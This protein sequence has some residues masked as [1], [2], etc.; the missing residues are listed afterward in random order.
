[1]KDSKG[2]SRRKDDFFDLKVEAEKSEKL[3]QFYLRKIELT[4]GK[5]NENDQMKEKLKG[6]GLQAGF[7]LSSKLLKSLGADIAAIE[8]VLKPKKK[9]KTTPKDDLNAFSTA[10]KVGLGMGMETGAQVEGEKTESKASRS[11][12]AKILQK[13]AKEA[14]DKSQKEKAEKVSMIR[15]KGKKYEKRLKLLKEK[16]KNKILE[17]NKVSIG[18]F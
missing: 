8:S 16:S 4:G 15:E 7:E 2:S 14:K 3:I 10:N 13:R 17:D 9:L 12:D 11:I 1:M 18:E 6:N 5:I